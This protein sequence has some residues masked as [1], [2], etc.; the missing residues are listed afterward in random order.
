[1]QP[2]P[3]TLPP[4][5][6]FAQ[7]LLA[8][9]IAQGVRDVVLCPGSRSAP[10]AYALVQA[11]RRGL[12][13]TH[14]RIDERT[15]GF[16][17]LGFGKA[18]PQSP[19]VVITTSGTAVANLHPAVLEAHHSGIPL[20]VISA[21]RPHELR[22]TGA[23]QTTEQVGMFG[24]ATHLA[25]DVSVPSGAPWEHL[26]ARAVAA[27]IFA[28]AVGA[29]GQPGPTHLNV[30]L[31]EP[32]APSKAELAEMAQRFSQPAQP[33]TLFP[34]LGG[35]P[36]HDDSYASVARVISAYEHTV[37]IAGDGSEQEAALIAH[38]HGWPIISE[39]SS[40]LVSH[41]NV[42]A[43]G[44][45]IL[46]SAST[47]ESREESARHEPDAIDSSFDSSA[48][49]LVNKV[50][51][52]LVFG[53][54][55]LTRPVQRLIGR[56]GVHTVV[57]PHNQAPWVDASRT[58]DTIVYSIPAELL[59]PCNR[60]DS[61][62]LEQWH[63]LAGAVSAAFSHADSPS[64]PLNDGL[65]PVV[66][67]RALADATGENDDLVLASS[68]AVRD[69]DAYVSRWAPQSNVL[70]HRGLAGIDGTISMAL[71]VALSKDAG[72]T[73]LLIGDLAFLHDSGA[74]LR[75]PNEPHVDLDI[76]VLNDNG[77]AIFGTLEHAAAGDIELF[78]RVFGTPHVSDIES[79]CAGFAVSW[80]APETQSD[81]VRLLSDDHSGIRVIEI[82]FPREQRASAHSGLL[83]RIVG[84]AG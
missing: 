69:A 60:V 38:A 47:F 82:R 55:T 51:Q 59:E 62:W 44:G 17:A 26:D 66:A 63:D 13:R 81:L 46:G 33:V 83:T 11:E 22:G 74:L 37:V 27:R 76:V 71:G 25:I 8:Q 24:N 73:R 50:E 80:A 65:A 2:D 4:S 31:R 45:L 75:G 6:A 7:A 14:V 57:F 68:S 70:A 30:G 35:I 34:S 56:E 54:P 23:N 78:E 79:L 49:G 19:A 15:A 39:P 72:R 77:G 20:I 12:V 16:L 36:A 40:G 1:M 29:G 5:L 41:S 18:D 64:Q 10:F 52:V 48:A 32:L 3:L 53:H 61:L 58:A 9:L 42:V 28:S 21:D 84:H 67:V 43:H